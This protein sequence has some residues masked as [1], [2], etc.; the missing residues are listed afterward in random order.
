LLADVA[1]ADRS[2]RLRLKALCLALPDALGLKLNW[3][4]QRLSEMRQ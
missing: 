3:L 2:A 4:L 1:P